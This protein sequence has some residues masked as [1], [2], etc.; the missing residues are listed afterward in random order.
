ML[1]FLPVLNAATGTYEIPRDSVLCN[2]LNILNDPI[3]GTSTLA[4]LVAQMNTLLAA[5]GTWA[6][7]GANITLTGAVCQSVNLPWTVD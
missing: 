6:V 7:S 3:T 5:M 1:T 4:T 2:G